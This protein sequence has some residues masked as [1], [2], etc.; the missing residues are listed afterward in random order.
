MMDENKMEVMDLVIKNGRVFDA[1]TRSFRIDDIGVAHGKIQAI[2]K[3][4]NI[5][6]RTNIIDAA[7]CIVA[8]GLIDMHC[9]IYPQFP[10]GDEGLPT[11]LGEA[12]MFRCGVT[13][14][15]DAGT[16]GCRDFW[17]FK[18]RFIS[19]SK[20]RIFAFLNIAAGGM[21][22]FPSEQNPSEFLPYT[23]AAI[24]RE[25][26]CVVGIKTAHYWV[27]IPFDSG[28]PAW[29]SVD[30]AVLAGELCNKP[31]MADFQPNLPERTYEEL[32]LKKL[33]KGDIHTH[34]YAQQFPILD[35]EEKVSDFLFEARQRGVLFDLG[36]GAGSFWFRNA[37]PAY[38]QGFYPD[39]IS[40]DLYADNM[41]GPVFDLLHIMSEYLAVG[42]PLEE[43][44]YR[45]TKRPAEIIGHPELGEL[46][47]GG[48]ADLALL[49]VREG[50]FQYADSGHAA[51]PGS[52]ALECLLTV[53]DG[54]IVYNPM[55]MG[56]PYWKDA[57]EPYW[58][59]PGVLP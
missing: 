16:C 5:D 38:E 55:A 46:R 21:V 26:D 44:L 25:A 56:L 30:S 19:K 2:S 36:H 34:V 59:S 54:E 17:Y 31:V 23:A 6:D 27:G 47:I 10:E 42:M 28:H 50:E 41:N 51:L 57:K 22:N 8:P 24:A 33:R 40:T 20:L 52:R 11:I 49:K 4:M 13:T 1:V 29:A 39:T 48:P 12:H 35:S 45:T 14:A 9:H 18:E 43:V 15:V 32:V 7:G 58:H 53:R 37:V 3:P